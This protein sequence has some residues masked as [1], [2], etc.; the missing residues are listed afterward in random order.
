MAMDFRDLVKV[1]AQFGHVKARLNPKMMQYIWGVK[2]NVHLIDVSKTAFLAEKAAKFLEET[3]SEG[4]HILFVGTKKAAKD[5]ISDTAKNLEM[6]YVNHRWIGGTISNNG[7]VRKSVTKLLHLEDVLSKTE[8]Y[9][10]Y[11]KKELNVYGKIVERLEK[12]VGGIRNL[13][14]PIGALVIVDAVKEYSAIK[15]AASVGIPVVAI[16]DTNGDPTFVDYVIPSNDDSSRA[17]K[18]IMDYLAAS[19]EN[20][21]KKAVS[22][23][24]V[25]TIKTVKVQEPE[26]KEEIPM[27]A[28][29]NINEDAD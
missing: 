25:D 15:E 28:T 18:L 8:K 1:G 29:F 16:V 4:K 14:W 13:R 12:N 7:Q 23:K 22:T 9:P 17:I 21:K 19:V 2:N 24:K 27:T 5:I 20:G 6:P 10:L 3:A 26:E 11:T